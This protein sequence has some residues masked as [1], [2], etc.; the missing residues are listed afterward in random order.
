MEVI[1]EKLFIYRLVERHP[2]PSDREIENI[3]GC[4]WYIKYISSK[5]GYIEI[6]QDT[7]VDFTFP[8]ANF[9]ITFQSSEFIHCFIG[10]ALVKLARSTAARNI[11]S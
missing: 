6:T 2:V 11:V 7:R 5:T 4:F 3:I 1:N 10:T 8:I 9:Q